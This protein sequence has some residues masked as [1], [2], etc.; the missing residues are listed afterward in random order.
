[1]SLSTILGKLATYLKPDTSGFV[2]L[3]NQPVQFDNSFKLASTGFV[4]RALGN[5]QGLTTLG[6][7]TTLTAAQSGTFVELNGSFTSGTVT[8]PSP[9]PN[10]TFTFY[11]AAPSSSVVITT[12]SGVIY[13]AVNGSANYTLT[14]GG[15]ITLFCDGT[16]WVVL[17]GGGSATFQS[18]GYSKSQSG[19]IL[20]WGT[21]TSPASGTLAVTFPIAF[22]NAAL[23]VMATPRNNGAVNS[24]VSVGS[25]FTATSVTFY[26]TTAGSGV[27]PVA[28][29]LSFSWFAVGY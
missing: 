5:F 8:L 23:S 2:S 10:L 22:P 29:A 27:A 24:I 16:N 15:S 12:P 9:S 25:G 14:T 11:N 6:G 13:S 7:T 19:M 26:T 28:S 3:V 17:S 20:Q 18:N 21:A 4:Q 1:M